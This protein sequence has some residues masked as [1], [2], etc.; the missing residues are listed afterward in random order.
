MRVSQQDIIPEISA[1]Q[2]DQANRSWDFL[3]SHAIPGVM[4]CGLSI[5][6][7]RDNEQ[8]E[9]EKESSE[10]TSVIVTM[11]TPRYESISPRSVISKRLDKV[12]LIQLIS[13]D[14][15]PK[16]VISST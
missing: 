2:V 16:S 7:E 10:R 13:L 15:S 12:D 5:V 3:E 1:E 8:K 6:H 11:W 14:P 4:L 9:K